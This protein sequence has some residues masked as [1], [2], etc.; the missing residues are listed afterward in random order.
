MRPITPA[1]RTSLKKKSNQFEIPQLKPKQLQSWLVK[2][3]P[4]MAQM[5]HCD[6]DVILNTDSCQ[7]EPD[8]W[9]ILAKHIQ[10][11]QR[12]Y[13][14]VIILHGTDTLAYTASA[15]SNLL[16]PCAIPI[17]ITG[18]QRPLATL[19]NDAR[20]NLI[21]SIEVATHA[22]PQLRNRV[23][24]VF[25]D[26]I[27]LGSRVRKKSAVQFS[28]FESPRFPPLAT[29]GSEIRYR[30]ISQH[31][32]RL[33]SKTALL[34]QFDSSDFDSGSLFPRVL[35]LHVTPDFPG[36]PFSE[37]FLNQLDGI[38]LTLYASGTAPTMNED[39]MQFLERARKCHLPIFAITERE[40]EVQSLS[41]YAAGRVLAKQKVLWSKDLTPEAAF[42]KIWL[43]C[44]LHSNQTRL[45]RY[46]WF[47][48]NWQHAVSDESGRG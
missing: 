6:V 47:Q 37:L 36:T 33:K 12:Q 10:K 32:P 19:R 43:Q 26:Q 45:S 35:S 39:F 29:I 1:K 18:A 48:K 3:V 21:S 20:T 5:A 2:Q 24:V 16:S 15:L 34:K 41:T 28:A 22:P 17:V 42:V 23:L 9:F 8:H 40:E 7:F 27:F 30:T 4:E 38:L 25:D 44:Q 31:L 11:K 46:A 13:Q 14:G